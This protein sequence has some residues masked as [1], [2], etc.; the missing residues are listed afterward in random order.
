MSSLNFEEEKKNFRE[1]YNDNLKLFQNAEL[2]IKGLLSAL[3]NQDE[4]IST[5]IISSRIKDREECI[6][7]FSSKYQS[8]LET[9]KTPYCIR[10]HITDLIAFRVVCLYSYEIEKIGQLIGVNFNIIEITDKIT[11]IESSEDLFGYK[12]LHLDISIDSRRNCLPEFRLIK[13]LKYEVQIRT[14]VQDAWSVL[15][16]KIKYKKNIPPKLKRRINVLSALFELADNEFLKIKTE[17]EQ[18]E[19]ESLSSK[20]DDKPQE[21]IL[22]VASFLKVTTPIFDEYDFRTS[23]VDGFIA[24]ILKGKNNFTCDEL[25]NI[26]IKYLDIVNEYA[27]TLARGNNYH[28]LN[29]YTQIRHALYLSDKGTFNLMLYDNQRQNFDE[30]LKKV[31]DIQ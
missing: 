7:K 18:L 21:Q 5:P 17:T 12:G 6:R 29:P 28:K 11:L 27:P 31:K 24:D 2:A 3:L 13:D 9:E 1:Y 15:E 4:T 10:D 19:A 14:V 26:L 20:K 23:H 30:W 16:H 8:K 25:N 22:D